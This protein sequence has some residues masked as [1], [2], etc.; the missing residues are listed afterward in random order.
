VT[1]RLALLLVAGLIAAGSPTASLAVLIDNGDGAGN[2]S[3]P[4]GLPEWA[5]VGSRLG[6]TSVIYIGDGW[7]LTAR[8]VGAGIVLIG[9]QRYDP[10]AGS[11]VHFGDPD[12]PA[13]LLA[14]RIQGN[15]ELPDLPVL[16]I[17][18]RKPLPGD[19]VILIGN[20]RN[21]AERVEA[22]DERRRPVRGWRW[23]KNSSKRWGTNRVVSVPPVLRHVDS[24]TKSI[25]TRF[26]HLYTGRATEYEAQPAL[27]DSGGA[28]FARRNR[29][30]PES[31]WVLSGVIFSITQITNGS[32]TSTF[33]GDFSFSVDLASYREELISAMRPACV[34]RLDEAGNTVLG[35]EGSKLCRSS[36]PDVERAR[37]RAALLS[38]T[39]LQMIVGGAFAIAVVCGA[40]L[41]TRA[42]RKRL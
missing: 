3:A 21:R 32:S 39:R 30:D 40:L 26:D 35:S 10:I 24:Q 4:P 42:S 31:P 22:I 11:L 16:E 41:I 9:D 1:T 19:D 33:Y 20:G 15:P 8:H 27:G 37:G 23:G 7:V 28:L 38:G 5:N 14:F 18:R 34:D 2:L 25:A 29:F 6:G 36:S 12:D 13:D 17:A